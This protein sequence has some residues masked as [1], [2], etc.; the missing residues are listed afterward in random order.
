MA[1][2][3][4]YP[5]I[6]PHDVFKLDV[7]DGHLLH[8]EVS[9]NPKGRPAGVLHSGPGAV[10]LPQHHRFFDALAY[11]I[12]VFD[13]RGA[14][15]STPSGNVAHNT[16][17]HLI[18]DLERLRSRLGVERWMLFGGSWGSTLAL[19]CAAD[20]PD[21]VAAMILRGTWL[22]RAEDI[23][24]LLGGL[25]MLAP[26][27][28]RDFVAPIP[29]DE[30][31]DLLEAYWL[32]LSSNDPA[33]RL[34]AARCWC[35]FEQH[36]TTLFSPDDPRPRPDQELLALARIEA[37]YFRHGCFLDSE[38]LFTGVARLGSTPAVIVHGRYDLLARLEGAWAL[39]QACAD[40]VAQD[41]SRCCPF[42]L[43]ARDSCSPHRRDRPV[44]AA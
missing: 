22:A 26:D 34:S 3:S 31:G 1:D 29:N 8:V 35:A 21:R 30:R 44:G 37:H 10:C 7:G 38:R 33:V 39:E 23:V 17:P 11:R 20:H 25:R 32:R 43:R 19:A 24:W 2:F 27:R 13:H 9:G 16:T 40:G 5:P 15:R 4:F 14:G 6:E 12:V 41:R 18:A 42:D 36:L 28:W